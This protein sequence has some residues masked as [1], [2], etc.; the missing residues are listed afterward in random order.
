MN[1]ILLY[2]IQDLLNQNFWA[3]AFEIIKMY[4]IKYYPNEDIFME[5]IKIILV[6]PNLINFKNKLNMLF[7]K[8][9]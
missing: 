4:T 9:L 6:R 3:R 8:Y 1:D 2:S 7:T 5:I